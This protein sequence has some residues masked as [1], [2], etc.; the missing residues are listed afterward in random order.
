M[1]ADIV[2][3]PN[4]CDVIEEVLKLTNGIGA[5]VAL[6]CLGRDETFATC[7]NV[8]RPGGTISSVGVYSKAIPIPLDGFGADLANKKIITSTCP[9][10]KERMR[11]LINIVA[12]Q[13]IKLDHLVTHKYALDDIQAAY[14]LF[15]KQEDG[16]FKLALKP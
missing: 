16:V 8:T 15:G 5:D 7:V 6:E 12:G 4:N 13:R 9:G 3:N 10:G 2:L 11:R 14:E 1:G